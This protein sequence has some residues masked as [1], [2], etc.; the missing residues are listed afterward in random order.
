[1]STFSPPLNSVRENL[2]GN[3]FQ[4][5]LPHSFILYNPKKMGG[6]RGGK[7]PRQT[8]PCDTRWLHLES[9]AR[10]RGWD[11][12]AFNCT[13]VKPCGAQEQNPAAPLKPHPG[14]CKEQMGDKA[15]LSPWGQ[16]CSE[17]FGPRAADTVKLKIY[18][19]FMENLLRI[20]GLWIYCSPHP[21]IPSC[22]GV[23]LM[24]W[25]GFRNKTNPI[26]TGKLQKTMLFPDRK[27][28]RCSSLASLPQNL[29]GKTQCK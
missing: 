3:Q 21:W 27:R 19:E 9:G 22:V 25:E 4:P 2:D 10:S 16:P 29:R 14:I 8:K 6:R 18:W 17:V 24:P 11:L 20:V 13:G 5:S 15:E 28:C 1:M 26:H 7:K 12:G 23:Q